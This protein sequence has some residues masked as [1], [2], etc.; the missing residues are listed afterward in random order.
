MTV[1]ARDASGVTVVDASPFD[2]ARPPRT[3]A[4][5]GAGASG[6]LVAANLLARGADDAGL[7]V[8]LIDP[9]PTTGCGIAYGT[10]DERHLLNVR[11]AGMSAWPNDPRDF[12]EWLSENRGI[13]DPTAFVPRAWYAEYLRDTLAAAQADARGTLRRVHDAVLDVRPGDG[14]GFAVATSSGAELA[15]DAVI[16]AIG[17]ASPGP[18]WAPATLRDSGRFVADPWDVAD[19]EAKTAGASRVLVV[20]TGLTMVDVALVLASRGVFVEAVSRNGL[21]PRAHDAAPPPPFE[22]PP[23]PEAP[24]AAEGVQEF[25]REHLARAVQAGAGWRAGMDS[26]RSI[27]NDLWAGMPLDDQRQ[28]AQSPAIREWEV[29]RHRIAYEVA[30]QFADCV[31]GGSITVSAGSVAG[32]EVRGD[33]L[34]VE[35]ADGWALEVD[36]VIDCT[37]PGLSASDAA[38]ALLG[39]LL[40]AGVAQEHP[41]GMGVEFL[42][43]G[44]IGGGPGGS[45][46]GRI[47]VVGPLRRGVLW[48]TTAV[49]ELRVQAAEVAEGALRATAP[50]VRA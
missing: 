8:L 36:A 15:A 35:L 40:A 42:P 17:F 26:L 23:P 45:V 14:G 24:T 12:V 31:Q 30:E 47:F 32:A 2:L 34:R 21:M 37:G 28:L 3:V 38:P 7:T 6:T 49:P 10:R 46:A 39:S 20:G 9:A 16:L 4:V 44:A 5:V 11:A 29:A 19:F 22:T 33:G 13:S 50:G 43:G 41:L 25:V 48:E 27:T 18:Q 1:D